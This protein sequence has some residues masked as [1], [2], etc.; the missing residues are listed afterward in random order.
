MGETSAAAGVDR[1]RLSCALQCLSFRTLRT[2]ARAREHPRRHPPATHRGHLRGRARKLRCAPSALARGRR[3]RHRGLLPGRAHALDARLVHALPIPGRVGPW[4][5]AARRGRQRV[6]GLLPRRHGLDVRP[7]AARR[8]RGD[9]PA[10]RQGPHLHAADRGRDRG[11]PTAGRALRAAPLAG[12]HHRDR[13]Q[14]L[15]AARGAR[16]DRPAEDP[17]VQR[18]LPRHGGRDF[19]APGRRPCRKPS[20]AARPGGGPHST[21]ARRGVQRPGGAR[22]GAGPWRRGLRHHRAG[23]DQLVHG[24]AR[25]RLPRRAAPPHARR[26]HAA[27][28]RRDPHDLHRPRRLHAR[29]RTASPWPGACRPASG[30][31]PT[32][33]RGD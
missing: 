20:R 4:R 21:C 22:G 12:R 13:R 7:L 5:R 17:G 23:D 33:S 28:D 25:P 27:A 9:P 3:P 6:R 8:G 11:R 26:G 2:S 29:L 30:G 19:R 24:A 16:R 31:S 18:L 10:G 14:P 1:R 15:R 32:R